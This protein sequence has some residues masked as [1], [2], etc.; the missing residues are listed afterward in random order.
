M[1]FYILNIEDI[2]IYNKAKELELLIQKYPGTEDFQA[3]IELYLKKAGSAENRLAV[4]EFMLEA[5]NLELKRELLYLLSQFSK[6][7]HI[8]KGES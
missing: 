6:L 8:L 2:G 3:T 1:V 5:K 7:K 4:L